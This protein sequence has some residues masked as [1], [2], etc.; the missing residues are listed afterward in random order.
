MGSMFDGRE[1]NSSPILEEPPWPPEDPGP[2]EPRPDDEPIGES[3][4]WEPFDLGPYLRGEVTPL[5]PVVG[6]RRTDGQQLLYPGL[7]HA[8]IAH[9]AAGKT[10]FAL[11]SV[12]AELLAGNRVVYLHFEESTPA[13]TIERLQRIGLPAPT[14]ECGLRF[15]APTRPARSLDALLAVSPTL[16]VVDGVNEA[17]VLHG[18]KID[19]EGWSVVRRRLVEP[20]KAAGAAVLECDHLPLSADPLRGDAYGTVHKGAVI[21]GTRFAL[22]RKERFGRGRRGRSLVYSTKDRPGQVELH[23]RDGDGSAVFLGTLIVDDTNTTP[24][25]LTLYAPKSSADGPDEHDTGLAETVCATIAA[26]PGHTVTSTRLLL[27]EL[28]KTGDEFAD[29]AV[30][31]AVDDLIVAGRIVEVPGRRG[32]RG[33]RAV[34]DTTITTSE[35]VRTTASDCVP[36]RPTQSGEPLSA[37]ASDCVPPAVGRDADAVARRSHRPSPARSAE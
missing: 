37:T 29:A 17:M 35:P 7:E 21:D 20:F 8:V 25:F 15:V 19:L 9:T 12:T 28:R 34:V 32:A 33:Y 30:R 1:F 13:S 10:W 6:V 18:V 27:A 5:T 4:T 16:V 36:P 24:D 31:D 22:V 3:S 14:I 2:P 11:A 23:G 26:L